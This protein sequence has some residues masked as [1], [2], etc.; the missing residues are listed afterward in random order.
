MI[1]INHNLL[2]L[3][4]NNRIMKR[5]SVTKKLNLEHNRF[6]VPHGKLLTGSTIDK[7]PVILDGGRTIIFISDKSKEAETRAN[8]AL[9]H[10]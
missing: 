9:R 6:K 7:F 5:D 1:R 10:R 4:V 8:Y 3:V 2:R